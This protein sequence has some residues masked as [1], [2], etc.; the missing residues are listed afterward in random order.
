MREIGPTS[1]GTPTSQTRTRSCGS[2]LPAFALPAYGTFGNA[3]RNI[4]GGPGLANVDFSL[5]KDLAIGESVTLQFRAEFFNL[6]N[7]PNFL[8][9]NVFFGTP[10][11]RAAAG[12]AGRTGSAVRREADLLRAVRRRQSIWSQILEKS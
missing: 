4:I 5:L 2:I 11:L 1:S 6:L 8:H 3:G 7:T 12:R 10:G 9:P